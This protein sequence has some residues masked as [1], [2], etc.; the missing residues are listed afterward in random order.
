MAFR[1][2]ESCWA[3][4]TLVHSAEDGER[5]GL[6]EHLLEGHQAITVHIS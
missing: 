1:S 6:T 4:G 3:V 2:G 5:Y